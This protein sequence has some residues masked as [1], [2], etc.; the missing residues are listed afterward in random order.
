M[1]FVNKFSHRYF[2]ENFLRNIKNSS[3]LRVTDSFRKKLQRVDYVNSLS[4]KISQSK[5]QPQKVS[6][7]RDLLQSLNDFQKLLGDINWLSLD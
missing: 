4:Y 1:F 2:R 7:S 3:I 6:I 5:I